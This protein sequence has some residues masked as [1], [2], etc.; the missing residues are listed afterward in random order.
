MPSLATPLSR[1]SESPAAQ[2]RQFG[3]GQKRQDV[4]L[5]RDFQ[6]KAELLRRARDQEG[7][8]RSVVV[9]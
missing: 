1:L 8:H 7:G 5:G 6:G 3:W 2:R 9:D 4:T